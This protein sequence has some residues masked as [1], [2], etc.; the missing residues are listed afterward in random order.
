MRFSFLR[1]SLFFSAFFFIETFSYG[2]ELGNRLKL[3][4]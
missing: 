4:E 1:I 3:I 2:V